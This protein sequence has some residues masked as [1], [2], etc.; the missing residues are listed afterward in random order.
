MAIVALRDG[1]A[2]KPLSLSFITKQI[3]S[4]CPEGVEPTDAEISEHLRRL[5][6]E[7]P[8][9]IGL[10]TP[11]A[12]ETATAKLDRMNTQAVPAQKPRPDTRTELSEQQRA[13]LSKLSA[14]RLL[15][16]ANT[17]TSAKAMP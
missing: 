12:E 17:N 15:D 6:P 1:T 4:R 16:F 9:H 2:I 11:M 7:H 10:V 14:D 3:R 5:R 8:A 13:K